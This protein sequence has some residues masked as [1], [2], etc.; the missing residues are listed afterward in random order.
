MKTPY[1]DETPTRFW[2]TGV[3]DFLDKTGSLDIPP[4]LSSLQGNSPICSAGS[5]FAQHIGKNLLLRG[6]NF[7][8]S[9]HSNERVESFGL[10][11]VYT[12]RQMKQWLEVCL[13]LKNWSEN[14]YYRDEKGEFW[15]YLLPQNPAKLSISDLL[16]H[17]SLV[18]AEIVANL[19][20]A[21]TFIFTV[22]LTEQWESLSGEAFTVCPGTIVG[23]F[24]SQIHKLHN[25]RYDEILN[26]LESIER[27]LHDINE[28]ISIIYTVSPVPLTATANDEHVIV[29]SNFSKAKLRAA[30]GEHVNQ[31]VTSSYFP[32]YEL[33]THNTRGDWRF[34]Q[35]MRTVTEQG[36]GFVMSHGF[37][38]DAL[39]GSFGSE[40]N[41]DNDL[42]EEH[43]E[44][45]KLETLNHVR[46]GENRESHVFLIGDSHMG[47]LGKAFKKLGVPY[48]GGQIMNG[49]GFSDKKFSLDDDN[50]FLPEESSDSKEIWEATINALKNHDGKSIIITNIGFQTHRNVVGVGMSANAHVVTLKDVSDY[51]M[52]YHADTLTI[53]SR[54]SKYAK[55]IFIED[56]NFYQFL[57][58]ANETQKFNAQNFDTYTDYMK[59]VSEII[60]AEYLSPFSEITEKILRDTGAIKN[61]LGDDIIHGSELYYELQA[62]MIIDSEKFMRV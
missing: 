49:S 44:E 26:D 4:L 46:S 56:P 42:V 37:S 57:S 15:D 30:V 19:T 58:D 18:C 62:R 35:N 10:G 9:V 25:I 12:T 39:L 20:S 31:S 36:V 6:Y 43:C 29:A 14:T 38:E 27:L 2:S 3:K 21:E 61:A 50:I 5:C 23:S 28:N 11:N 52:S 16:K 45:E 60:Q 13:G 22:G 59:M 32:S 40:N 41:T 8:K 33:I 53:L 7:L 17:R 54:L 55:I 24:D 51:F 34:K 47:K 1:E 48:T